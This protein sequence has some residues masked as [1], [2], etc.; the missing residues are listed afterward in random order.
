[1]G[2]LGT[3]PIASNL[4]MSNFMTGL[5]SIETDM[6]SSP[7]FTVTTSGLTV[8]AGIVGYVNLTYV[9]FRKWRCAPT[10]YY[11]SSNDSCISLCP[12]TM[13]GNT[14]TGNC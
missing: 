11:V 1:M 12:N 10:T 7:K 8:L 4:I 6:T 9:N 13:Y 3:N 5:S 2:N 14:S